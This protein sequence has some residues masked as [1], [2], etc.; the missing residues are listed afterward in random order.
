MFAVAVGN[1]AAY[2]EKDAM[3]T[4]RMAADGS[5][6]VCLIPIT[7]AS[8][9]LEVV[10]SEPD[11]FSRISQAL[12]AATRFQVQFMGQDLLYFAL[13]PGDVLYTPTGY[14]VAEAAGINNGPCAGGKDVGG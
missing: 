10:V 3:P 12:L 2:V 6:L 14:V 11:L 9:Y 7:K 5:R 1:E 4:L 8:W 13:G